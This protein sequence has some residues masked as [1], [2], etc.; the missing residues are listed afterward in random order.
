MHKVVLSYCCLLLASLDV[1]ETRRPPV[2]AVVHLRHASAI[3]EA[4][5]DAHAMGGSVEQ[6]GSI[7]AGVKR[8]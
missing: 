2:V 8:D 3:E 7:L 1:H 4:I 6:E 5:P